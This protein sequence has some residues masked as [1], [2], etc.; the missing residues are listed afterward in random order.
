LGGRKGLQR[1]PT[2]GGRRHDLQGVIALQQGAQSIAHDAVF[3]SHED[4][5]F[6]GHWHALRGRPLGSGSRDRRSLFADA[7]WIRHS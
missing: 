4:A 7:I 2:D 3:I 1:V 6:A 5:G